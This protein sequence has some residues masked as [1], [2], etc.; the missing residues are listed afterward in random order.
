[1]LKLENER[2]EVEAAAQ[3]RRIEASE[4]HRRRRWRPWSR[5]IPFPQA[6]LPACVYVCVLLRLRFDLFSHDKTNNIIGTQCDFYK[7]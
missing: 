4:K 1:M 6:T 5:F 7:L 2:L 3:Y